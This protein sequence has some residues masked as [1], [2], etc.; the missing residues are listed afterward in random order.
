MIKKAI[1]PVAGLGT[2]FLPASKSIP[3]EMV[4]VVDGPAIEY[5]VR[6]AVQAVDEVSVP[7]AG[8]RVGHRDILAPSGRRA[9]RAGRERRRR[10]E[11]EPPIGAA[12]RRGWSVRHPPSCRVRARRTRANSTENGVDSRAGSRPDRCPDGTG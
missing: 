12:G 9:E 6:E 5:V 8:C 7:A 2:R 10:K 1:L 3:K 11:K 4:T